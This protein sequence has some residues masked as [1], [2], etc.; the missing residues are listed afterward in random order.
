MMRA[1][2][3]MLAAALALVMTLGGSVMTSY[4]ANIRITS[5]S[6]EIKNDI[7]V[8]D[9][10]DSSDIRVL[11]K[12]SKYEAT[13]INVI[14]QGFEW[15]IDD[16]PVVE[17]RIEAESGYSFS[18][19]SKDVTVKGSTSVTSKKEDSTHLLLTV[20][21]PPLNQKAGPVASAGWSSETMAS[22]SES[23]GAGYYEVKLYR[24][25]VNVKLT[26][27]SQ[28]NSLD[29][30]PCMTRAGYY[31]YKVR[32]VNKINDENKSDW[33]DSTEIHVSDELAAQM[34]EKYGTNITGLTEPGQALDPA[35]QPVGWVKDD[36]GWWYRNEGGLYTTND[37]QLI[38]DKWYYFDS[39]GYMVTGWIQWKD[40]MYYCDL[41]EGHMLTNCLTPDGKRV[42][43]QGV[44]FE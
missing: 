23:V 15:G 40:K 36:K 19:R 34:R 31:I 1:G 41:A 37:W 21:L 24:E 13:D 29:M 12:T 3:R 14:N 22:W 8:G 43:S 5:I 4:A 35:L 25:G 26:Q 27:T 32:A 7:K 16:E 9:P 38:N 2:K 39:N 42:D 17:I 11:N 30:G 44:L 10:I 20:T 6:I 33:V 18:V 28:T